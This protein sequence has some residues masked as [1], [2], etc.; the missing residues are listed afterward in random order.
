MPVVTAV[1]VR[2]LSDPTRYRTTLV[3]AQ[4]ERLRVTAPA[5]FWQLVHLDD[6]H[7]AA[8]IQPEVLLYFLRTALRQDNPQVASRLADLLV[9]RFAA[10]TRALIQKGAIPTSHREECYEDIRSQMLVAFYSLDAGRMEFWEANF[11]GC[12]KC[13]ALNFITRYRRF[14]QA[15][16]Q[17]TPL[18]SPLN[19]RP[20][21]WFDTRED[22]RATNAIDFTAAR[23]FLSTLDTTQRQAFLLYHQEERTQ[24]EI[25]TILGLSE[26]TIRT[27][28]GKVQALRAAFVSG[29][30]TVVPAV[31]A[32]AAMAA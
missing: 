27:L 23:A 21:D 20:V 12:L 4:I 11:I 18:S 29:R 3:Q 2:P 16:V 5:T 10:Y 28:L 25:A 6:R 15:E 17:P 26:R 9:S 19:A 8:Y 14:T 1:P 32:P 30:V 7:H 13:I 22:P 24:R 31:T